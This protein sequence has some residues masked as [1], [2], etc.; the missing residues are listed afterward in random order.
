MTLSLGMLRVV[1]LAVE[2]DG[3]RVVKRA[4]LEI[5]RG[6]VIL[7]LG[8]N[9]SGKSSLLNAIAG[10]PR[11]KIVRGDVLLEGDSIKD[12]EP[13]ERVKLGIALAVQHPP[14][15]RGIKVRR[16]LE[17]L[18]AGREGSIIRV[19]REIERISKVL[20]IG[21]LLDR[22]YGAGFSGGEMKRVEV[23]TLLALK[24]RIALVD[25]PD[26]GVDV[27][28]V[29]LIASAL[30]LMIEQ[31][32]E[33]IL[34]VTHSGFIARHVKHDRAYVMLDGKVVA[35]GSSTRILNLV[36]ERGFAA[37]KGWR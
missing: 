33:A 17:K 8:P 30:D 14:K 12:L 21:E 32:T 13:S 31:G 25:E 27:D 2:V 34:L 16:L 20:D 3:I 26:S 36:L 19:R 22:D 6:E 37:V 15:L 1:E 9:A 23:A 7:L 11:F 10:L 5:R 28:S 35:E 18:I 29:L 4:S 24:P